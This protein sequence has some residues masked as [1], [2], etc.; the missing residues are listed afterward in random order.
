[1][2][3]L[4]LSLEGQVPPDGQSD[5]NDQNNQQAYHDGTAIRFFSAHRGNGDEING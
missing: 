5:S 3:L 2:A 4:T 1:M